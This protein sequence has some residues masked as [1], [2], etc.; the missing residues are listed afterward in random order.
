MNIA[1]RYARATHSQDLSAGPSDRLRDVDLVAAAGF[2][3]KSSRLAP[4]L[5]R[6]HAGDDGA[7]GQ[8]VRLLAESVTTR[9][10]R[11]AGLKLSR[12]AAQTIAIRVLAWHR[13][14]VCPGCHGRRFTQVDGAPALTGLQCQACS[15]TGR[16][17]FAPLFDPDQ[18]ELSRWLLAE[19][20][21]EESFAGAAIGRAVG[22]A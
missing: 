7:A 19:V 21:R 10:W 8:L 22:P 16:L 9:A 20:E 3:A 12:E 2:A 14:G 5:L 11:S 18:L 6:L 13:D 17:P 1:A 15:G 4:A